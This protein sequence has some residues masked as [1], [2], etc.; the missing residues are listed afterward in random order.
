MVVKVG[1]ETR[2][3]LGVYSAVDEVEFVTLLFE[4]LDEAT[5]VG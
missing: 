4:G 1:G 2:F 3:A 5:W